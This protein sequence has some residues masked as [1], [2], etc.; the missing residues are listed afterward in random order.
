MSRKLCLLIFEG[1]L[2]Y[3]CGLAVVYIR[4][5]GEASQ[6]LIDKSGWL[7]LLLSTVVAHGSFYLFD[8]YD[9]SLIRPRSLLA[10]RIFQACGLSAMTLAIIFYFAPQLLVGRNVFFL[11]FVLVLTVV[12]CL[13]VV[14]M[15]FLGNPRLAE[16]VLIVGTGN[17]AIELAREILAH[18]EDGFEVVGFV[19][20]D[21]GLVG[22][23]LINPRVIGTVSEIEEVVHRSH[24]DRIVIAISDERGLLPLKSLLDLKLRDDVAIEEAPLFYERLAGK[25]STEQLRP[26]QL[27][28]ANSS[29]WIRFYRRWHRVADVFFALFGLIL[30]LPLMLLTAIAIKLDSQGPVFYAQ[31]RVGFRNRV[32]RI[33][34]FRSMNINAEADGPRWADVGD[35]RVTRVGRLIRKLRIDELP[36]LINVIRGEMSFIGP[37]PERP[38]F[39]EELSRRIPYYSQRHWVKPGIT[40][41]A[42]VRYPYG[43]SIKA[44]IEKLQYDLYY[45]K[46][47]SLVLDTII[48]FETARIVLF[49]RLAR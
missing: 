27:I 15:W 1:V 48:L 4:F 29:R 24:V 47:Q 5:A 18:R 44:A 6:V 21:P 9:F 23:S 32:F 25:I 42:Q 34:K 36:Q 22:K 26:S 39:V 17:N 19:G 37:R 43:A 14:I 12:L 20:S 13:R 41:W 10:I 33:I 31:E 3:V 2:I 8:L 46:N 49:G 11:Q 40:G 16:Q 28:F 7:K 45:I 38:M 35:L 30:T